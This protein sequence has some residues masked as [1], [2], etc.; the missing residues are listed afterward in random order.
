MHYHYQ[1][2]T[3]GPLK[4]HLCMTFER[5]HQIIKNVR[6][7]NFKNIPF[8]ACKSVL[9]N[10]TSTYFN[11]YGNIR[12][13]FFYELDEVTLKAG[14]IAQIKVNGIYYRPGDIIT[15]YTHETLTFF[16]YGRN[17]I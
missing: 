10:T 2:A 15:T 11:D 8:S 9:K 12:S 4:Q 13:E 1:A 3:F 17:N 7:F 16:S 6:Y 14:Y 5:K